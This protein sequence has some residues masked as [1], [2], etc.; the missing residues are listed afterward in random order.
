MAKVVDFGLARAKAA[1]GLTLSADMGQ[2]IMVTHAGGYTP[3]YCSPEQP[4]GERLTRRTDTWS[5]GLS[6]PETWLSRV[7]KLAVNCYHM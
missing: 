1:A 4:A 6:I 7:I 5:W 2:S 3:A